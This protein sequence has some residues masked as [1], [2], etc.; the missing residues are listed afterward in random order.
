MNQPEYK[1]VDFGDAVSVVSY[2]LTPEDAGDNAGA[3]IQNAINLCAENGGES[4]LEYE[5]VKQ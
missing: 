3:A 4:I 2:S 5:M 1:P